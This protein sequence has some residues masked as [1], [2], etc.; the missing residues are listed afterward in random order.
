MF[1]IYLCFLA[2]LSGRII[3]L[4]KIGKTVLYK[5]KMQESLKTKQAIVL[6]CIHHERN[7]LI[8]NSEM[9]T[10]EIMFRLGQTVK[11]KIVKT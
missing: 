5:I 7:V 4:I 6:S 11:S 2:S 8:T 3:C 1:R 10:K 9:A